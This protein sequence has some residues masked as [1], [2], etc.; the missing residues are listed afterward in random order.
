MKGLVTG[1]L[2]AFPVNGYVVSYRKE[3]AKWET[4]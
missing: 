2:D 4:T 1:A 3:E